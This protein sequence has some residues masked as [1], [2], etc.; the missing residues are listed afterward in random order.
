MARIKVLFLIHDLGQGGAEKVLVNLV[1]HMDR[2]KYDITVMSLFGGGINKQ[3]L[4]RS[5]NY[6]SIFSKSFPGNSKIM[7]V[8]S[9][10]QLHSL[11]ITDQYDIEVSYLEGP[12]ARII[13]GCNNPNTKTVSW[14][15]CTVHDKEDL[16]KAFRN[17][18]EAKRCYTSFDMTAFVSQENRMRFQN[19]IPL[20]N[21]CVMYNTNETEKIITLS[22][23]KVED[24]LFNA[25]YISI[26][27]VG[28]LEKIKGF[29]RLISIHKRLIDG[30]Y[31]V[32][33]YILGI[34]SEESN[35]KR[36]AEE[37]SVTDSVVFLGYKTNPY[38]YIKKC[39]LYVCSSH[40]EGF[41]TAATEALIVGT[42]V[43]TVDVSGMKEMLGNNEYGVI[44][45]NEKEK[46]Y[47][48]IKGL[49]DNPDQLALYKQ[50]AKERGAFFSTE[51]TTKAVE[52]MLIELVNNNE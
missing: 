19:Y 50:K 23:E 38:K 43:C 26:V 46:L 45:E 14:I 24:G 20:N 33:T 39:D 44:T 15:H 11:C 9:P 13:S 37:A 18:S 12:C 52:E 27:G 22:D 17:Y 25:Q 2:S 5:I 3:F 4:D 7:K 48:G 35:L 47:M 29:D 49:L 16:S 51:R 30:G 34:G 1:N 28:K 31:P 10:K 6:R 36:Q 8:L 42:P 32:K 41:S 40:S 21:T